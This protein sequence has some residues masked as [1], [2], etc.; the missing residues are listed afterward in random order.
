MREDRM[1]VKLKRTG[2]KPDQQTVALP[3][4]G[5]TWL[6]WKDDVEHRTTANVRPRSSQVV[7]DCGVSAAG[8]FE[9]AMKGARPRA[10]SRAISVWLGAWPLFALDRGG[11]A[12]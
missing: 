2:K 11:M 12:G 4:D 6:S 10:K 8:V 3:K 5:Q 7:E 1:P 9:G